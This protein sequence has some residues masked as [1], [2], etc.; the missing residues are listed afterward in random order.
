M[1]AFA[2]FC[3]YV[4]KI[5]LIHTF[6]LHRVIWLFYR[7]SIKFLAHIFR[8]LLV[9]NILA[10]YMICALHRFDLDLA[11]TLLIRIFNLICTRFIIFKARAAQT[12]SIMVKNHGKYKK[13]I[14]TP[15]YSYIFEEYILTWIIVFF[16]GYTRNFRNLWI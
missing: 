11:L 16:C 2:I 12:P 15:S 3:C 14:Y 9:L 7:I 10:I 5:L 13:Q 4:Y 1:L 6:I 8:I